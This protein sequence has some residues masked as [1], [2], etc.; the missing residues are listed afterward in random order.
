M[1]SPGESHKRKIDER[2]NESVNN[3]EVKKLKVSEK[4]AATVGSENM[5]KPKPGIDPSILE[6]AKKAVQIQ[7]DLK[8]KL[9]RLKK[10]GIAVKTSKGSSVRDV[11]GHKVSTIAADTVA[12]EP[13]DGAETTDAKSLRKP[14]S[15]IVD[16][17]EPFETAHFDPMLGTKERNRLQRRSRP[18][19]LFLKEGELT[20]K[21]EEA[22][23][24]S[25][26][27]ILI[28]GEGQ[29]PS[30]FSVKNAAVSYG[31]PNLVPIG[32][33]PAKEEDVPVPDV[34]W[35]DSRILVYRKSYENLEVRQDRIT[36]LI[37]HPVLLD[38]P[39]EAAP[40]PPQPLRLTKAEM[41]KLRTQRR[42][43]REQEKQELIR[44][45]L[46][47]PPKPKVKISNL[48]RVL[49]A[50]AAAD[51]T[52]I[53]AEVRRQM[54]ERAAAHED[55]NLAR[56]LTPSERKEKKLRKLLGTTSNSELENE[57][58]Q[59]A[60]YK[61]G[62]LK[63]PQIKFKVEINA[64]ENHLGGIA[65]NVSGKFGLVLVEGLQKPLRRYEKL[66]CRRIKWEEDD[67][68]L[69]DEL[70]SNY[71]CLVW[72]GISINPAFDGRFKYFECANEDEGRKL[73]EEYGIAHYWD[74]VSAFKAEFYQS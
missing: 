49:G 5:A 31:D 8:E 54:A 1:A 56:M 58:V 23:R 28:K 45:G 30:K 42:L 24:K 61:V 67:A 69:E 41:K 66:M 32:K 36:N 52:A 37:E 7:K 2:P 26:P 16:R 68:Q 25:R 43:A 63:T 20:R 29:A 47:E 18:A 10:G 13:I 33:R 38:P 72:S 39:I 17:L 14:S 51:P 70:Q 9:E 35:W 48:M 4:N 22:E 65:V 34:E 21:A 44:Q 50:D 73:L 64:K 71:C 53:E 12:I 19:F 46:L 27:A 57:P 59:V 6:K 11:N 40:P 74:T 60:V 62:S 55:R 15:F 3:G